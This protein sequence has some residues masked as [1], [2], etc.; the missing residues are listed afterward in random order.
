MSILLLFD[1]FVD[2]LDASYVVQT[3]CDFADPVQ[4][5]QLVAQIRPLLPQIRNVR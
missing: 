4:R 3:A 2:R 5:D 1:A